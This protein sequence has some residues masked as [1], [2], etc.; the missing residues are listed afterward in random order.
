M[1]EIWVDWPMDLPI[2]LGVK[3]EQALFGLGWASALGLLQACA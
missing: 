3:E 2:K 1:S